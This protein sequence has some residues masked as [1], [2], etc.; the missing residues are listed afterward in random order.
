MAYLVPKIRLWPPENFLRIDSLRLRV[1]LVK[2]KKK[3]K[4]RE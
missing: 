4:K 3:R 1:I 2:K